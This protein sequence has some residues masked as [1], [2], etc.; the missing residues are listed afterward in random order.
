MTVREAFMQAKEEA[1]LADAAVAED[2]QPASDADSLGV[3]EQ[4]AT[5][6][7]EQPAADEGGF[8]E[9]GNELADLLANTF[10]DTQSGS[11]ETGGGPAPGSDE[12]WNLELEVQ[13][14]SGPQTL[15]IREITDGYLRQADYTQKTQALAEERKRLETAENFLTEFES[16]PAE[17]IRSLAVQAGFID[18][19]DRPI[20]ET[21]I[22]KIPTPAE[23]EEEVQRR[24]EER[25]K[26]D[27]DVQSAQKSAQ[28]DRINRQ[29]DSLEKQYEMPLSK[30]LRL[31]I[32]ERAVADGTS[33]F[34]GTLA[35]MI[36]EAQRK[37]EREAQVSAASSKR[38]GPG[39]GDHRVAEAPE[40]PSSVREAW[41]MAKALQQ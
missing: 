29:F 40:A 41:E 34:G 12:F 4:A 7:S 14:V 11:E 22:A 36:V 38:P 26:S 13:T 19:G 9:E 21:P 23:I 3:G 8:S 10:E 24:V 28:L 5:P 15:S 20:T 17:F 16:N 37:R 25:L 18:A 1:G 6:S 30:E 33:D 35:K 27:P 2:A 32:M 39:V 31:R